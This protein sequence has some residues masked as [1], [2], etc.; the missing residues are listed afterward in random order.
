[1][2]L[3][4]H[5]NNQENLKNAAPGIKLCT[6]SICSIKRNAWRSLS[7]LGALSSVLT[8]LKV[9]NLSK[10]VTSASF[11]RRPSSFLF[12]CT[13]SPVFPGSCLFLP[14]KVSLVA[15]PYRIRLPMQETQETRVPSPGREDP[16]EK[17]TAAPA[18]TLAWEVPRTEGPCGLQS[19]GHKE[20]NMT[21]HMDTHHPNRN[22][23]DNQIWYLFIF[24][25]AV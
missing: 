25:V 17:E 9:N 23:S 13:L 21:E 3:K 16:R 22:L 12:F 15:L 5:L 7:L 2:V 1:M 11:V 10:A 19:W 4:E 18:S 14:S 20:A 6:W 24:G 8:P